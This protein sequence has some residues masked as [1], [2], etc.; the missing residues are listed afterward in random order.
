M[1]QR[2]VAHAPSKRTKCLLLGQ[3]I[4]DNKLAFYYVKAEQLA[5]LRLYRCIILRLIPP[6]S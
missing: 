4:L 5:R 2:T 1:A 6:S 3:T